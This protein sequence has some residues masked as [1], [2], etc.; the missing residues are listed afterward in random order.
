M[1][2]YLVTIFIFFGL[3]IP[4]KLTL[5]DKCQEYPAKDYCRLENFPHL[6]QNDPNLPSSYFDNSF[7]TATNVCGPTSFGVILHGLLKNSNGV[8]VYG[9][10]WLDRFKDIIAPHSIIDT[11]SRFVDS[12]T[13]RT[14]VDIQRDGTYP[15]ELMGAIER[16]TA[17]TSCSNCSNLIVVPRPY[18]SYSG[19]GIPGPTFCGLASTI[20]GIGNSSENMVGMILQVGHYTKTTK[21]VSDIDIN[22]YTRNGGHFVV[23][24][25]YTY[26]RL[27]VY[28]VSG[29]RNSSVGAMTSERISRIY[30][31]VR[32]KEGNITERNFIYYNEAN[33]SDPLRRVHDKLTSS[34]GLGYLFDRRNKSK[35]YYAI[36]ESLIYVGTVSQ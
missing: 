15:E 19:F 22:T 10:T 14:L 13:D 27:D 31:E 36:I 18:S 17:S 32:D 33:P 28:E 8:F 16:S 6:N 21:T 5:A 20:N 24:Y 23:I 30:D 34:S 35:G 4:F 3:V 29:A 26:D 1:K 25:G 7:G 9:G 12:V 11:S 2:K